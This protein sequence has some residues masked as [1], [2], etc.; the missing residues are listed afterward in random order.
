MLASA[1][2]K[3]IFLFLRPESYTEWT[4]FGRS[5]TEAAGIMT[6]GKKKF[7]LSIFTILYITK[8][9]YIYNQT[10]IRAIKIFCLTKE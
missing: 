1:L 10:C 2:F 9:I 5:I 6:F 8:N 3:F 4:L 7:N